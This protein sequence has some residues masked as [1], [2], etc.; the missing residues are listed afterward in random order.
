MENSNPRAELRDSTLADPSPASNLYSVFS[1]TQKK[2][3]ML[4]V[5]VSTMFPGL[6][7]DIYLPGLPMLAEEEQTS[8]QLINISITAYLLAQGMVPVF[9]SELSDK[10][11][12]WP[13]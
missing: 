3:I 6:A 10:I 11:G 1:D 13:V 12:H 8:L 9:F 2:F 7:A 5:D 4:L